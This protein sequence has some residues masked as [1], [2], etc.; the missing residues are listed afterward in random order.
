MF[1]GRLHPAVCSRL[2]E[3][4][5]QVLLAVGRNNTH[6]TPNTEPISHA[7]RVSSN[8]GS[9]GDRGLEVVGG[10]VTSIERFTSGPVN[11]HSSLMAL[12]TP[13]ASKRPFLRDP[14]SGV[15]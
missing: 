8:A 7:P 1:D 4:E 5:V 6:N 14:F 10:P 11:L 2:C 15:T 9:L 13:T 12:Y 3:I